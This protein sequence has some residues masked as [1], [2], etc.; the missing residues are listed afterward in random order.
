MI[1]FD[2]LPKHAFFTDDDNVLFL[3]GGKDF[4]VCQATGA[5]IEFAPAELVDPQPTPVK[6]TA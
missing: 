2:A 5:I 3:K 1:R 6:E 4:A